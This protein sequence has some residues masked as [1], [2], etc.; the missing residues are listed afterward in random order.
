MY[1]KLFSKPPMS[2]KLLSRPPFK[3]IF[4][5]VI[6]L[7]KATHFPEG[8]FTPEELDPNLY[9]VRWVFTCRIRKR[10]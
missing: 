3:Y 6:A 7:M 9:N 10:R 5:V 2:E 4:D 8:L 1:T